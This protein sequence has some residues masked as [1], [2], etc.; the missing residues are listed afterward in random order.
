[1]GRQELKYLFI[2]DAFIENLEGIKKGVVPAEK[3]SLEPLLELDQP[4]EKQWKMGMCPNA[5][6]DEEES[7]FKIWYNIFPPCS[8][9]EEIAYGLAYAV[10]EDGIH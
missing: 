4:W 8:S 2:D 3:V 5:M 9:W 6:Y 1:M 7:V 10:S